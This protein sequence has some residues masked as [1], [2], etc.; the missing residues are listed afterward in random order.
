M[1]YLVSIEK[2]FMVVSA[3][4][5]SLMVPTV[6]GYVW[7]DIDSLRTSTLASIVLAFPDHRKL[8]TENFKLVGSATRM[9]THAD[10]GISHPW[11]SERVI[12]GGATSWNLLRQ[13]LIQILEDSRSYVEN[14][15]RDE[16]WYWSEELFG[17]VS[18]LRPF[19]AHELFINL[20]YQRTNLVCVLT[21]RQLVMYDAALPDDLYILYYFGYSYALTGL[22]VG[23]TCKP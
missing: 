9:W 4:Y 13:T 15:L 8:T 2:Y 6:V 11:V 7:V 21:S 5:S 19:Q 16:R 20:V 14:S 17:S 10:T 18:V 12:I 3:M 23:I 22:G 1:K